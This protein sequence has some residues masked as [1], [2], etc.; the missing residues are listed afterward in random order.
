V[1]G[2]AAE[3]TPIE[4][5]AMP[6]REDTAA[7]PDAAR[8]VHG[9]SPYDHD[10]YAD[11]GPVSLRS[12]QIVVP[13]VQQIVDAS[14]VVD[15]GCGNGAWLS[16]FRDAGV[17][18]YLGLDGEYVRPGDL[19]IDPGHF[20]AVDLE[21]PQSLGR[22]FDLA[23]SLEVAEHLASDAAAGLVDF[24]VTLAPVVLFSAAIPGQG[25]VDHVNEQWPAYWADLFAARGY[26]AADVIRPRIWNEPAVAGYFA[27]NIVMY[28][29]GGR[30]DAVSPAFPIAER[31]DAMAAP[32]ALV[33]PHVL[34]AV[35]DQRPP[36]QP[37]ASLQSLMRQ[38]PA[39]MRAAVRHRVKRWCG[40]GAGEQVELRMLLRTK[41]QNL[42]IKSRGVVRHQI[43]RRP[44]LRLPR[45]DWAR[46]EPNPVPPHPLD[47]FRFFAV[48][49]T[50]FEGDVVEATVRSAMRQG[51]ERVYLVDNDSPDDT[52][53]RAVSAG[54]ILARSFSTDTYDEL[55]RMQLMNDVVA[56]VSA[57]CGAT[58]D[59][60]IW[61]LWLDADEFHHGPGGLTLRD[62][63]ATLDRRFRVVGAR[64][65]NHFPGRAPATITGRH[66][67]LQQPLCQEHSYPMCTA[68][69][70]KHPLQRWDRDASPL[71]C[72]AGFHQVSVAGGQLI[73]PEQ[74]I[75]LHH[76]P[77]RDEA[78]S[79]RRL[80]LLCNP[81]GRAP[82]GTLESIDMHRRYRSLDAVY[83]QDWRHVDFGEAHER[84]QV[85]P[86][87]WSSQVDARDRA[88]ATDLDPPDGSPR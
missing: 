76:F 14:S 21:R 77:Y 86:A 70:R 51:C 57:E 32:L 42:A 54:A 85:R 44:H 63:L 15:V 3:G 19:L 68:G 84:I 46:S 38:V 62:Y 30:L 74:A 23:V 64:F 36:A 61:W 2:Q 48:M 8:A 34:Q 20:R 79:R 80:E 56:E 39:A 24:L 43:L 78:T 22:A 5:G 73:E 17:E 45:T 55:L 37:P 27:Q 40:S 87:P 47:S 26:R 28:A 29:R 50:W 71:T 31:D 82:D 10:F 69:H 65:F 66:P 18:D 88:L 6:E 49:G 25:G 16:V 1:A 41:V 7:E 33:H 59:E 58:G 72:S 35:S 60:H 53:A 9:P 83:R 4:S 75:F 52:V 11:I 13:I 81:D 12:A 67:I